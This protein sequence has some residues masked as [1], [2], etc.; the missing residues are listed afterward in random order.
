MQGGAVG[1][2][3]VWCVG[4]GEDGHPRGVQARDGGELLRERERASVAGMEA[5]AQ[6]PLRKG[7]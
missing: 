1:C 6:V 2:A 3:R 7:R 4:S 5:L